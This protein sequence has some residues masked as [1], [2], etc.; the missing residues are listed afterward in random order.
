VAPYLLH[1]DFDF[2][3]TA[4]VRITD[5][6]GRAIDEFQVAIGLLRRAYFPQMA[7]RT[8]CSRRPVCYG[9]AAERPLRHCF[10]RKSTGRA[11]NR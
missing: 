3:A 6:I 10:R 5:H 9:G 4:L 8:S 7:T 2:A 11:W 1:T